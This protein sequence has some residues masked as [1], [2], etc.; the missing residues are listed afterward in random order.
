MNHLTPARELALRIQLVQ[1]TERLVKL[2]ELEVIKQKL[3][4]Y[5]CLGR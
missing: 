4:A 1:I 5:Q 2:N 3:H